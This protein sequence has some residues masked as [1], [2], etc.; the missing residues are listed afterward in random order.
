MINVGNVE[1][2]V[3]TVVAI[4]QLMQRGTLKVPGVK[5]ETLNL[6]KNYQTSV[7]TVPHF[8]NKDHLRGYR[9]FRFWKIKLT[10]HL[11]ANRLLPFIEHKDYAEIKISET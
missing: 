6:D 2:Q 8:E 5:L 9:N 11:Q 1:Q 3:A 4:S 10:L 7:F